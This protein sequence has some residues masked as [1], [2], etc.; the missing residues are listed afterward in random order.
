MPCIICGAPTDETV[1]MCPLCT[2][3]Q[4]SHEDHTPSEEQDR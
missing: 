4:S 2:G 1:T 3:E